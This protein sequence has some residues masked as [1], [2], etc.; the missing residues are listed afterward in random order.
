MSLT[1]GSAPSYAEPLFRV[2]Y[3]E[4]GGRIEQLDATPQA[5][6][7]LLATTGGVPL[8]IRVA[9]ATSAAVGLTASEAIIV[10][11]AG[12]DAVAI[13]INRSVSLLAASEREVF[14]AFAVSAG[15]I[16]VELAARS[17]GA[18]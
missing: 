9:A 14:D 11:G 17:L 6:R 7:H 5:L 12:R 18:T 15:T 8:A 10:E 16:D 4:A 13:S 1:T 2:W 3:A